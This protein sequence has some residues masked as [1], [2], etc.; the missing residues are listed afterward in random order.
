MPIQ[1]EILQDIQAFREKIY[2][3]ETTSTQRDHALRLL[4]QGERK[5]IESERDGK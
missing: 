2:G 3:E 4:G 1:K 5:T